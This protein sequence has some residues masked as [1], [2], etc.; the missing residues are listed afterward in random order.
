[1][2]YADETD[3]LVDLQIE[4]ICRKVPVVDLFGI[5]TYAAR[6]LPGVQYLRTDE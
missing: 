3:V 6:P 5:D 2:D 4:L 1:M